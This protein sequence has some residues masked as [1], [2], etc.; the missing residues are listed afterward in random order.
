MDCEERDLLTRVYIEAAAKIAQSGSDVPDMTSARWKQATSAARAAS[1][2]ALDAL[3]RHRREHGCTDEG[4][5]KPES[6]DK[7]DG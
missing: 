6:V 2:A 7:W 4:F 5:Q 1:K 3:H